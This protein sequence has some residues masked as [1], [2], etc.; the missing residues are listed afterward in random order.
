MFILYLINELTRVVYEQFAPI[1]F[2]MLDY[3][4]IN[5]LAKKVNLTWYIKY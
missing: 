5:F 2:I 3:L 4:C 1:F